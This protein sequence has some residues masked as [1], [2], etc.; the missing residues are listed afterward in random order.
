MS[1]I[2]FKAAKT[3]KTNVPIILLLAIAST[4]IFTN[5]SNQYLWQDEAETALLAKNVLQF[6]YPRAYDGKNL[7][8][9]PI[10]TGY[11]EDYG[12][13]YH[14]WMQFY[15]TALSF[16]IFGP[17]TFSARFPFALLGVINILL[18]YLLAYQ[19]TRQRFV[20]ICSAFLMT[21]SVPYLLLMRQCRYYAPAIFLI[22]FAILFYSKYQEE[23][24]TGNLAFFSLALIL[25]G[26]TVHGMFVPM[27][28]AIGLHYLTFAFEKK[29]FPKTAVAGVI[30]L[31]AVLPWF[32]YS[33]SGAHVADITL[34]RIRKNLEF[35]L[36]M[37]NKYLF[38]VFFFMAM[39]FARGLWKR[40]WTIRLLPAEKNALKI[41]SAVL[42]MSLAAFG[43]AQE[44]NLRY[45]V[46]FIPL[47]SIIQG[48]IL[49]RLMRFNRL[50]LVTFLTLSIF[51]GVFN[52]GRFEMFL[53][54][55]IYEITHDYDGPI[56]GIVTFLNKNASPGDVVKITYG[57]MPVI[58]YTGLEVDNT[59]IFDEEH[60]P[61]WIVFR[62]WWDGKQLLWDAYFQEVNRTY[63][64]HVLDYPDIPW[65]NRPGDLGY[66]RFST[67]R[68]APNIIIFE[69]REKGTS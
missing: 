5:I 21:M 25:L 24:S 13:R 49:L 15:I 1:F 68:E 37:I 3:M 10:R 58:F 35:E 55:Y 11:A 6:G 42:L 45:L 8:N 41:I 36:R 63:N 7:I 62:R 12:W 27:Y 53:P 44:R 16:K 23:K 28:A 20:A 31:A 38:P 30:V 57:D 32:L 17:G 22:L 39:Y 9:P 50:L 60:L 33:N 19:L 26:Y 14:P 59:R 43:F 52:M 69:R 61:E 54:K 47:L 40:R 65:E 56:E 2:R 66:H 4:L 29:T 67:D 34:E 51:T 48:L 18:L 46:Y 64:K